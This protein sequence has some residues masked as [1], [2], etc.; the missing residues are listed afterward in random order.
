MHRVWQCFWGALRRVWPACVTQAQA[1]AFDMFL[2]LFPM[3]LLVL[4]I[5][6]TFTLLREGV[7]DMI[8]GLGPLFPPG[9]LA[10][11]NDFL[12]S[13]PSHATGSI[14]LGLGGT[15]IA[16]TQMMR[17]LIEGF[18]VANHLERPPLL[19]QLARGLILLPTTLAP[20]VLAIALVVFGKQVRISLSKFFGA[21]ALVRS[22]VAVTLTCCALVLAALVLTVVYRVGTRGVRSWK[23]V[24]PGAMVATPLW[25]LVSWF[26]GVYVRHVPYGLVYGG[27]AT[28]VGL[29]IWMNLTSIIILVG[30]AYNAEY[31]ALLREEEDSGIFARRTL[32]QVSRT[33]R[34]RR[35]TQDAR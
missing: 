33:S 12:A 27:L 32:I 34:A 20:T 4:G 18:H 16:G 9:T 13:H 23:E 17:I 10:L 14:S 15:L 22:L 25:W 30:S 31:C 29:M 21:P 8:T 3:L 5:V 1:A 19:Q 28:A 35:T 26:L 11:V 6:S 2:A 24:L 7:Q